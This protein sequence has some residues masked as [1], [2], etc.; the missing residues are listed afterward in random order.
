MGQRISFSISLCLCLLFATLH[1]SVLVVS[2]RGG[3]IIHP[4]FMPESLPLYPKAAPNTLPGNV[5]GVS[6]GGNKQPFVGN[7]AGN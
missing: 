4:E 3:V 6:P 7:N 2:R 5:E 1:N